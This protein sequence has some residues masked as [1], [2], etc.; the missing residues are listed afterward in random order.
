MHEIPNYN[1][2]AGDANRSDTIDHLAA[3][4]SS[5]HLTSEQAEDRMDKAHDAV[6]VADLINLVNDL[7]DPAELRAQKIAGLRVRRVSNV[8][9]GTL[10][11]RATLHAVWAVVS[12]VAVFAPTW[13]AVNNHWTGLPIVLLCTGTIFSGIASLILDILFLVRWVQNS[14]ASKIK[15]REYR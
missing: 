15:P 8:L 10:S 11:G 5:G 2:R 9:L 1:K 4:A 14:G 12:L 3:C 13:T 6:T 7:P